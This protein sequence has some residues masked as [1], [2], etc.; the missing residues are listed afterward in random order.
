MAAP[1]KS[2]IAVPLAA[3][4]SQSVATHLLIAVDLESAVP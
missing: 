2:A 4:A 1:G 3:D